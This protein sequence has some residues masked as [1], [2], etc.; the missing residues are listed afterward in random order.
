MLVSDENII[1]YDTWRPA[2]DDA[3]HKAP[4]QLR[5]P[6]SEL[7]TAR[8]SRRRNVDIASTTATHRTSPALDAR[9]FDTGSVTSGQL[10]FGVQVSL[11]RC[12]CRFVVCPWLLVCNLKQYL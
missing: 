5:L 2:D 12:L 1:Q 4:L 11:Y 9:L 10:L 3:R 8:L 7:D 6:L